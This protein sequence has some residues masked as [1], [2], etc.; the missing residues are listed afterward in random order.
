MIPSAIELPTHFYK[1]GRIDKEH[2]CHASRIFTHNELY[3]CTVDEFDDPFDCIFLLKLSGSTAEIK[4]YFRN[5]LKTTNL[6]L[7]R[8]ERRK[9]VN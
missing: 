4:K 3:F 5:A 9:P 2:P 8:E 1:Y 6:N 7:D